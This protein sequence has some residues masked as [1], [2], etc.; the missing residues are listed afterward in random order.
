[1][2]I[3]FWGTRGAIATVGAQTQIYGGNTSCVTVSDHD[4]LLILDAGS[5]LRV[6]AS[7]GYYKRFKHVHILLTHLHIDHIQGLGFFNLFFD[8]EAE[9]HLWGP[10]SANASLKMRL[11]RYLSPPLFPVR[12]RDFN[13]KLHIHEVT[14]DKFS[15]EEFEVMSNFVLHPGPTLGFR[16]SDGHK[17]VTFIPDHEPALGISEFPIEEEWTSGYG[18]AKSADLLIHDSSYSDKEYS[19][20]QGWGHSSMRHA[21]LFAKLAKVKRLELFHHDPSHDDDK[22]LKLFHQ[23]VDEQWDFEVHLAKENSV[24]DL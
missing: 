8:P 21:L 14:K 16:I 4:T 2:K 17:V 23:T 6:L 1:M 9:I 18:L 10:P 22:L 11:N 20:R 13:C 3:T 19:F 24:I 5:G 12:M 15:I 7:Q